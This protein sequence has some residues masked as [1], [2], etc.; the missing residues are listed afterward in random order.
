MNNLLLYDIVKLIC[1]TTVFISSKTPSLNCYSSVRENFS[2]PFEKPFSNCTWKTDT[3]NILCP[4]YFWTNISNPLVPEIFLPRAYAVSFQR[5]KHFP[6]HIPMHFLFG[7]RSWISPSTCKRHGVLY[8][9]NVELL[10]NY[11]QFFITDT[12]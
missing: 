12:F 8:L 11:W 5:T 10:D 4:R 2:R 9:K 7:S 1:H 3:P 6:S